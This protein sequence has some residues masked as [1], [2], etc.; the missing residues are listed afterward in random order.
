MCACVCVF[1]P[2][3]SSFLHARARTAARER[4]EWSRDGG[5]GSIRPNPTRPHPTPPDPTQSA[6]LLVFWASR[7]CRTFIPLIAHVCIYVRISKIPSF[8][9]GGGQ[10]RAL[11]LIHYRF[12]LLCA[13]SHSCCMRT[14]C[15]ENGGRGQNIGEHNITKGKQEEK[16][17][18]VFSYQF[19]D[20]CARS[21]R[22]FVPYEMSWAGSGSR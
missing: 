1:C 17:S 9:S 20:P 15:T 12:S 8:W 16:G 21:V 13:L 14:R 10:D 4:V 11:L 2:L 22:S 19:Q 7:G 18:A 6:L 3:L 5:G